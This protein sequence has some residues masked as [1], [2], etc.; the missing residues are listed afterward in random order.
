MSGYQAQADAML[1]VLAEE[2]LGELLDQKDRELRAVIAGKDQR[3]IE[4]FERCDEYEAQ[5]QELRE[6]GR[7]HV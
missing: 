6:I 3:M 4:L 1:D 7:A 5:I 2:R